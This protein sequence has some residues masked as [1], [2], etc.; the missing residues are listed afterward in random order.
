MEFSLIQ[1]FSIR[2]YP[3]RPIQDLEYKGEPV[4]WNFQDEHIRLLEVQNGQW[5]DD[6]DNM[7]LWLSR[8]C[9]QTLKCSVTGG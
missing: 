4:T 9:Y 5:L 1:D 6:T 8:G 3:P 7:T 2:Q